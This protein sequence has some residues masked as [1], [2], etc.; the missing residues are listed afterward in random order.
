MHLPHL[1]FSLASLLRARWVCTHIQ[2]MCD[3]L[4]ARGGTE[5]EWPW[6]W[7]R[8]YCQDW[9][10]TGPW[11]GEKCFKPPLCPVSHKG[12]SAEALCHAF[13][14]NFLCMSNRRTFHLINC[15]GPGEAA[16][17][18]ASMAYWSFWM[19]ITYEM[20]D[21]CKRYTLTLLSVSAGPGSH[22]KVLSL[23]LEVKGH[24]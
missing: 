10:S 24:P 23:H 9:K 20:N 19:K 5:K 16:I 14:Y 21:Q 4:T 6:R 3:H 12:V 22:V 8:K 11:A 2:N 1:P 15:W 17:K 7:E 18:S 13:P